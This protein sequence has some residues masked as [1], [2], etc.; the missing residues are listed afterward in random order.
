MNVL[1]EIELQA[2]S[3]KWNGKVIFVDNNSTDDTKILI[4]NFIK[5]STLNILYKFEVKKGISYARELGINSSFSD[6][7]VFLDDDNIPK[8]NWLNNTINAV[9]NASELTAVIAGKVEPPIHLSELERIKFKPFFPFLAI[10]D[11]GSN[12][13]FLDKVLPPGAGVIVNRDYW[14]RF[15]SN[16][17]KLYG[18]LGSSLFGAED[19]EAI[20][21]IQNG[22]GLIEYNPNIVIE[23]NI[24]KSR[25]NNKY[26]SDLV[27]SCG[28]GN[29][30][31]RF[32]RYKINFIILI[33]FSMIKAHLR[34]VKDTIKYILSRETNL[35]ILIALSYY[36]GEISCLIHFRKLSKLI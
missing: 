6:W 1:K 9:F 12:K 15:V 32:K 27:K 11:F 16:K 8:D 19:I 36:L 25:F 21:L 13:T 10:S 20:V 22:G 33:I 2:S 26:L 3:L 29:I 4:N 5:K 30:I 35:I 34:L 7:I 14:E 23:H 17:Q 31:I 28:Y 24:E 18:R